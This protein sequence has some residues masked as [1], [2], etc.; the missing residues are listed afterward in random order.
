MLQQESVFDA[1]VIATYK[2]THSYNPE[3][4]YQHFHQ[5]ENH[6]HQCCLMLTFLNRRDVFFF[7]IILIK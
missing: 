7:V 5:N 2:V 4:H 3:D 1:V 6:K